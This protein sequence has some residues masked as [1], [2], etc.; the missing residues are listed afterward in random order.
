MRTNEPMNILLIFHTLFS[1]MN[2]LSVNIISLAEPGFI[3]C[4]CQKR[5][6]VHRKPDPLLDHLHPL[7]HHHHQPMEQSIEQTRTLDAQHPAT[8]RRLSGVFQASFRQ[9]GL[10]FACGGLSSSSR[11]QNRFTSYLPLLLS[12]S[13]TLAFR[14]FAISL[15]LVPSHGLLVYLQALHFESTEWPS[16]LVAHLHLRSGATNNFLSLKSISS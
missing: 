6:H 10:A 16:L 13:I 12:F 14:L 3:T 5:H 2:S 8:F 1:I 15:I 4:I 7:H 11:G 9:H